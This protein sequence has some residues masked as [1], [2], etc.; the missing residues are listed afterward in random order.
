MSLCH[1][2]MRA[3][4]PADGRQANASGSGK[5]ACAMSNGASRTRR[6]T[7]RGTAG[8]IGRLATVPRHGTDTIVTPLA[9]LSTTPPDVR[10]RS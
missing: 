4:R 10:P 9:R 7:V 2:A 5:W 6:A 1:D 8:A 3:A